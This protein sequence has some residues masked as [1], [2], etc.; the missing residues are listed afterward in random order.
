[1]VKSS[2]LSEGSH[3]VLRILVVSQVMVLILP[4]GPAIVIVSKA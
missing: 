2:T 4:T 3:Y 1:M